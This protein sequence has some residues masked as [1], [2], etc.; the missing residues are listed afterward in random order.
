MT[1]IGL[2]PLAGRY[3]DIHILAKIKLLTSTSYT[4]F[5]ESSSGTMGGSLVIAWAY[6]HM[7]ILPTQINTRTVGKVVRLILVYSCHFTRL[8]R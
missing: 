2:L 4:C 6:N 8:L 7:K 3:I 1:L 5:H